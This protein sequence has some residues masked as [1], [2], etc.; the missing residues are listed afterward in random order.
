MADNNGRKDN[1]RIKRGM[2][3]LI[4]VLWVLCQI[5]LVYYLLLGVGDGILNEIFY[6]A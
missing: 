3:V 6:A 4:S 1:K 5:V 2:R